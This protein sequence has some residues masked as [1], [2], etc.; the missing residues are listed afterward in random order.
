MRDIRLIS[1]VKIFI[2]FIKAWPYNFSNCATVNNFKCVLVRKFNPMTCTNL[3][4]HLLSSWDHQMYTLAVN[5]VSEL[6]IQFKT[7]TLS[8]GN[9][10]IFWFHFTQKVICITI[11]FGCFNILNV[12][13]INENSSSNYTNNALRISHKR[14]VAKIQFSEL[15]IQKKEERREKRSILPGWFVVQKCFQS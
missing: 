9:I 7:F 15:S 1:Q 8:M 13:Q 3:P 5:I 6:E 2:N 14:A 4:P 10:W 11:W 12:N